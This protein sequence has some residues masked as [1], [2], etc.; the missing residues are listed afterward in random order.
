MLRNYDVNSEA[1]V[2]TS[3]GS[4]AAGR[5]GRRVASHLHLCARV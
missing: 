2:R 4:A 5:C 3:A 1:F